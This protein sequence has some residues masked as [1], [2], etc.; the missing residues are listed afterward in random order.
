MKLPITENTPFIR[1]DFSN[2]KIWEE[3]K[4]IIKTPSEEGF[5]AYISIIEDKTF[6]NIDF[7]NSIDFR[8]ENCNQAI[9]VIAD[10]ITFKQAEITFL[11]INLLDTQKKSFRVIPSQLWAV[12]NNLSIANMDFEDFYNLDDSEVV[13]RGF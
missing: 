7:L 2:N 11:V 4:M 10:E 6:E 5:L 12:E 3:I 13:F 1:T 9:L 8:S